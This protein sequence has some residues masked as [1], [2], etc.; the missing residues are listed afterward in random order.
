MNK[1]KVAREKIVDK[2]NDLS[3]RMKTSLKQEKDKI[4][5]VAKAI[6]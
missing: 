2:K 1:N 5:N 4:Q 6:L 3:E